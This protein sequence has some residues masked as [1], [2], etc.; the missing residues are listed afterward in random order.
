MSRLIDV[1]EDGLL[2]KAEFE[3]RLRKAKER[4]T[5][6]RGEENRLAAWDAEH[7]ELT[8]A[9]QGLEVFTAQ[10]TDSLETTDWLTRR[11][12]IRTLV[13]SV[14]IEPDQVRITYRISHRPFA[15]GPNRG[16][17]LHFCWRR[18]LTALGQR[19]PQ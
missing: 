17:I 19:V 6:L 1:Y 9:L 15:S 18:D 7:K 2:D 12:I 14:K 11:E 16:R 8:A 3:P 10:V 5:Q 4:L 13:K